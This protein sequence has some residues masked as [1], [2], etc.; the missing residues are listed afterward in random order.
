MTLF[1][2]QHT[3]GLSTGE[4][5]AQITASERQVKRELKALVK[6]GELVKPRHGV[7]ALS[8]P[9]VDPDEVILTAEDLHLWMPPFDFREA[10]PILQ[11][12]VP[13]GSYLIETQIHETSDVDMLICG[14]VSRATIE[15]YLNTFGLSIP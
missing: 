2:L 10:I 1:E 12:E 3:S 15:N 6:A 14:A 11:T 8:V 7:Y 4:I 9:V 5:V 13:T